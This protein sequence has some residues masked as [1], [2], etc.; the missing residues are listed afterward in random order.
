MRVPTILL[1]C[2]QWRSEH[3]PRA[4]LSEYTLPETVMR[5][6]AG[7]E[8]AYA[9]TLPDADAQ[10]QTVA[11][12]FSGSDASVYR[13][14]LSTGRC[15]KLAVEAD[16]YTSIYVASDDELYLLRGKVVLFL[17]YRTTVLKYHPNDQTTETLF[18]YS[19]G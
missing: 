18:T 10:E 16:D 1:S 11:S 2:L 7:E 19:A 8:Y 13:I 4:T 14:E 3:Q 6:I 15:E 17:G 9:V 12:L 5:F